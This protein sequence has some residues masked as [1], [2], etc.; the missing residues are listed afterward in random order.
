MRAIH[1]TTAHGGVD[2]DL[3]QMTLRLQPVWILID[4]LGHAVRHERDNNVPTIRPVTQ[5][6][7]HLYRVQADSPT[8][9]STLS[10]LKLHVLEVISDLRHQG[11]HYGGA[12]GAK[13]SS[14][15]TLAALL[16]LHRKT[17]SRA[18]FRF[19]RCAECRGRWWRIEELL[20]AAERQIAALESDL[21]AVARVFDGEAWPRFASKWER[22]VEL[23][24]L[25]GEHPTIF[26]LNE[27]LAHAKEPWWPTGEGRAGPV[28]TKA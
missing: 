1:D 12:P 19:R 27:I 18:P 15:A 13:M 20:D 6:A 10:G 26:Q 4:T 25:L 8:G 11:A 17:D 9:K 7:S 16:V 22:I 21:Q 2:D 28:S 5:A 3:L 24:Q 14:A 23:E